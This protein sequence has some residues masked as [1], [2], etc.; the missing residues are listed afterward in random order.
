[1]Q[2]FTTVTAVGKI[3]VHRTQLRGVVRMQSCLAETNTNII[4]EPSF[5]RRTEDLSPHSS[6][7]TPRPRSSAVEVAKGQRVSRDHGP[8]QGIHKRLVLVQSPSQLPNEIS[9]RSAS[10]TFAP[11]TNEHRCREGH[12]LNRTSEQSHE[13]P[14]PFIV[15]LKG[16]AC[17]S[18]RSTCLRYYER[19]SPLRAAVDILGNMLH[20][21]QTWSV[22]I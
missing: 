7:F 19:D 4:L 8:L 10:F 11:T 14:A 12:Q 22:L 15:T 2:L 16:F 6:L 18:T 21:V 20:V 17:N 3:G 5:S 13:A 9:K 1:M